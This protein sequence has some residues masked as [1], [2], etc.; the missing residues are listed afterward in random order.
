MHAR[1]DHTDKTILGHAL[2][3]LGQ[4]RREHEIA[5]DAQRVDTAFRPATGRGPR[6]AAMGLF[7]R[8]ASEPCLFE[9]FHDTFD[10]HVFDGC[11][12]K[13]LA[14]A[15]SDAL[16]AKKVRQKRPPKPRLWILSAGRPAS[17]LH[18]YELRPMPGFPRGFF[19]GARA[20]ATCVIVVRE[21][22]RS[23]ETLFLRLFGAGKVRALALEE[24]A[25]LPPDAWERSSAEGHLVALR[26]RIPET[27]TN[28]RERRF[29][30]A[31]DELYEQ[32]KQ[33]IR[34]EGRR[35]AGQEVRQQALFSAYQARFG[36][37]PPEL[38]A[39]MERVAAEPEVFS[40]WI[41]VVT[42]RPE[43]DIA[44]ALLPEPPARP[45]RRRSSPRRPAAAPR[46]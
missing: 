9:I 43:Q 16:Q 10:I 30:M 1:F 38:Q 40:H 15:H 41:A 22:P 25:A 26:V 24:L 3:R 17:V 27:T 19:E 12:R 11:V 44:A 2:S 4:V 8:V 32:W 18:G 13:Q 5:T 14:L 33:R 20:A 45:A 7:G 46:R 36:S 39:A 31:T 29:L 23:R 6:R 28:E 37:I 35:E 21:L 34:Q 42:T